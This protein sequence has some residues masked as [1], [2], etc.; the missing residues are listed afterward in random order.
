MSSTT[1]PPAVPTAGSPDSAIAPAWHTAIVLLVMLG[2][3]LLGARVDLRGAFSIHGR[4]PSYLFVMLIEWATVAFIWW[5][6]RR[7]GVRVADLVA[8][9]WARGIHVLRDFGI[10]IA[11]IVICG[12]AI[13]GLAYLLKVVPPE[14]MRAMMPQTWFE[15]IAWVLLSTDRRLLRGGDFSWISPASIFCIYPLSGWRNCVSGHCLRPRP[16]ISGLET[17]VADRH[18]RC[19]F[20]RACALAPQSASGNNRACLAGHRRRTPSSLSD[21]VIRLDSNARVSPE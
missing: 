11:F 13:Q 10:G 6:L 9:S 15:M 1:P 17:D 21:V 3:S 18:L 8:G 20:R 14:E 16:W 2:I 19:L 12:G 5:G 7:R 4:L